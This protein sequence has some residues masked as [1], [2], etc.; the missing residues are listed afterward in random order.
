MPGH[1]LKYFYDGMRRWFTITA[2][3]LTEIFNLILSQECSIQGMGFCGAA[4]RDAPRGMPYVQWNMDITPLWGRFF[5]FS[6]ATAATV[7]VGGFGMG[8]AC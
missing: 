7:C 6:T 5:C 3:Y 8:D 4:T 2:S 1:I